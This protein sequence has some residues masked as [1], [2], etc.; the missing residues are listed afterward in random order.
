MKTAIFPIITL[1]IL[2][3]NSFF[4]T[5][6]SQDETSQVLDIAVTVGT[7]LWTLYGIIKNHFPNKETPQA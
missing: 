6:I 1:I 2:V 3:L 4:H 5:N 7:G